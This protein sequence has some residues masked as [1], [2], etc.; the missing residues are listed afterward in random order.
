MLQD[1]TAFK[2]DIQI[3]ISGTSKCKKWKQFKIIS[4]KERK[5]NIQVG[6]DLRNTAKNLITTA[7]ICKMN[8][9]TPEWLLKRNPS[10][11]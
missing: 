5:K 3:N 8:E 11:S 4:P 1:Q 9:L 7:G 6:L 2:E 10:I